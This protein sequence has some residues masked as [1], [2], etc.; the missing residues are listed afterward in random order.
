MQ[1]SLGE[2]VLYYFSA[3]S[4]WSFIKK[5]KAVSTPTGPPDST[6]VNTL[7]ASCFRIPEVELID[8]ARYL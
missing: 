8:L 6:A 4:V 7:V 5:S 3:I 1:I 2:I